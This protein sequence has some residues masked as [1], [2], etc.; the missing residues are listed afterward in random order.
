MKRHL[1][2]WEIS[3]RTLP[4]LAALLAIKYALGAYTGFQGLLS[5]QEIG[6]V[7]TAGVFLLGFM[8]SGTLADYKE[9]ERIPGEMASVLEN[10]EELAVN[11]AQ[12]TGISAS[13]CRHAC[14]QVINTT[15]QWFYKQ[16]SQEA[17]YEQL[18]QYALLLHRLSREG[19]PPPI[20][21]RA[22]LE[23]NSLRK[24]ITRAGVISR[25]GFLSSGYALLELLL[26]AI[27]LLL[28]LTRFPSQVLM[29]TI[30]STVGLVYIYLYFL[31]RD[32]DD[33]FEYEAGKAA[34]AAEV[35]LFPLEEYR[36]RLQNRLFVNQTSSNEGEAS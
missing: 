28:L 5:L 11:A 2:K 10:M 27:L 4:L 23:L 7:V 16:S 8:L 24:L 15:L 6:L 32:I 19:A 29:F 1:K 25:T 33:P 3:L 26:V 20:I 13:E 34:G 22:F 21:G 18:H 12:Q 14:M 31:I 35:A 17:L 9:S 36:R 30:T